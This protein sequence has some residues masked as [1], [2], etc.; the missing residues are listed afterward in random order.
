M[1]GEP[2][3]E[4]QA[5]IVEVA[6]RLLA[7]KGARRFTVQLLADEIGVTGGAIYRH[8][9]SMDEV[10]GAVV[11]RIGA[12]LFEGFPPAADDP[13][14]RLRR[15]FHQ[16][17]RSVLAHPHISRLLL[18]DHLAQAVGKAQAAR[19]DE[20]KRRSQAFV[21]ECLREAEREGLLTSG[22]S[23]E[24]GAVV[25]LGSILALAHAGARVS[26][27]TALDRLSGEVWSG[28]ERMLRGPTPAREQP[29]TRASGGPR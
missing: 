23:A 13:L 21:R 14:E 20:F 17:T 15:F 1:H 4:R 5:E 18:S 27:E 25:V 19:L 29:R 3:S 9:E 10:M 12:V 16:R 22:M 8:F 6:T 2:M 11:E 26:G 28:I 7:T 24:A